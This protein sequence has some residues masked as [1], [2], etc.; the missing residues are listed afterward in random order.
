[1]IGIIGAMSEEVANL[2][3]AMSEVNVYNAAGMDFYQ[4]TLNSREVVVVRSG[5]GKVTAA[6]CSQILADRFHVKVIINTGIAGSL[7]NEINIGDIVLSEDTLQHDMDCLLY[8]SPS[9]RDP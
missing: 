3:A 7:R 8:T 2:K 5:I 9:P 4:G 1:M 6:V